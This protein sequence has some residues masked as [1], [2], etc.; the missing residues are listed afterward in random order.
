MNTQNPLLKYQR[1]VELYLEL[2]SKGRWWN[3][4]S[5]EWPDNNEFPIYSMTGK[6]EF[7]LKHA[8]GL[9]NGDSTVQV[10]E[11]CVPNIKNAWDAPIIDVDSLFIGIRIASVGH[12]ME[13]SV[14]CPKCKTT[15]SYQV[16]LREILSKITYPNY[17]EPVDISN[18]NGSMYMFCKPATYKIAALNGQEVYQQQK[19][20]QA[21]KSEHLSDE[22]KEKI[23]KDSI[24]RLTD[25]S[26]SRLNEYIE[27]IVVDDEVVTD[28]NYINEFIHGADR[29]TFNKIKNGIEQFNAGYKMPK[30]PFKCTN[31]ECGHEGEVEFIFDPSNFFET[32]S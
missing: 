7:A 11:S 16:D 18:E 22:Q 8:E 29:K 15:D 9:M 12:Y 6:D 24:Y 5:I 14:T 13:V 19:A 32:D 10:I 3:K 28:K 23:I 21:V 25:I 26:V 20:L 2:P 17:N 30:I 31:P 27:K 1:H 4:D